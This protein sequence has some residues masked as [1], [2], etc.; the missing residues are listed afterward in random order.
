MRVDGGG[1]VGRRV[2]CQFCGRE[3]TVRNTARH[4]RQSC[5]VWNPG[6]GAR[7]R[8]AVS[9][10]RRRRCTSKLS[11]HCPGCLELG[12][13]EL[14]SVGFRDRGILCRRCILQQV[15]LGRSVDKTRYPRDR[16]QYASG[17]SQT[18]KEVVSGNLSPRDAFRVPTEREL[19]VVG[20]TQKLWHISVGNCLIAY[21]YVLVSPCLCRINAEKACLALI[22][23]LLQL[24][25]FTPVIC[26]A[27]N[28]CQSLVYIY[29]LHTK[30][31]A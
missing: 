27:C 31:T 11:R 25:F 26:S 1:S 19:L 9:G 21:L 5:R 16:S 7:P 29:V 20:V 12:A 18:H 15:S 8:S 14:V 22:I 13:F 28:S 3:L 30:L 10:Q 6:G 17:T 2:S 23:V 24:P 4:L